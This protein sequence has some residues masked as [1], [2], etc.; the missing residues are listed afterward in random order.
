MISK[1]CTNSTNSAE[2]YLSTLV[3]PFLYFSFSLY[4]KK[5]VVP[6]PIEEKIT[7]ILINNVFK[8][9]FQGELK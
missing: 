1:I 4:E 8:R 6:F 3:F 7:H 2:E 9:D 5:V